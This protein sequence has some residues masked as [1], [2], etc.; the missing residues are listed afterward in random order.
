M[1]KW[2][3]DCHNYSCQQA[4]GGGAHPHNPTRIAG[5]CPKCSYKDANPDTGFCP[6]QA[7]WLAKEE[8]AEKTSEFQ[9]ARDALDIVYRY[10]TS[11][12]KSVN[13]QVG[14]FNLARLVDDLESVGTEQGVFSKPAYQ[15]R[16]KQ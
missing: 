3:E 11:S 13:R 5:C 8:K 1:S 9:T 10:L 2:R 6:H 14:L 4:N 7:A 12:P 15:S 16:G